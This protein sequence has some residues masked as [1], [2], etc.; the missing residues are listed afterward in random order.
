MQRENANRSGF[1]RN[2]YFVECIL[3]EIRMFFG[4]TFLKSQYVAVL[5]MFLILS[6]YDVLLQFAV[7]F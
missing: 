5:H 4:R 6:Q 2:A 7:F 3:R 1:M